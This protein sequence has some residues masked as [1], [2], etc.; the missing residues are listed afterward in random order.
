MIHLA[1]NVDIHAAINLSTHPS[2]LTR[3]PNRFGL[4]A[5][6]SRELAERK[7]PCESCV[8]GDARAGREGKRATVRLECRPTMRLGR[9]AG[10]MR[11]RV[12]PCDTDRLVTRSGW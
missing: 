3:L 5:T 6:S 4:T 8:S 10:V 2:Y 12:F 11:W 9:A 7:S 1:D